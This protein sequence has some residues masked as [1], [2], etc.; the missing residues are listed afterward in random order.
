MHSNEQMRA[1][2]DAGGRSMSQY[3][4]FGRSS[5]AKGQLHF[6]EQVIIAATRGGAKYDALPT[7]SHAL[8]S[9]FRQ[10]KLVR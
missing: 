2:V 5:N 6:D 1:P 4:Q 7:R 10:F 3:S 9:V 8:M